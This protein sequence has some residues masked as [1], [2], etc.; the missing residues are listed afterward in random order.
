LSGACHCGNVAIDIELSRALSTYAPRVCDCDFC[1][2]H[3]AAYISDAEGALR[4]R[5]EDH[6]ALVTYR[7]GSK[8]AEFLL[9]RR[10]GILLGV[11]YQD[12]GQTYMAVNAR[13]IEEMTGFGIDQKVSPKTLSAGEK[14]RRWREL[15]FSRVDG[16]PS[17]SPDQTTSSF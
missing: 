3:G 10:C 7:Q 9:C 8:Q 2:L 16:L 13:T 5:I 1:R 11:L 14:A 6:N 12:T 4:F 17:G 15:W